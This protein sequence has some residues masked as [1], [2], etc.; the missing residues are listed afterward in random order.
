MLRDLP[1]KL[2]IKKLILLKIICVINFRRF[3]CP[4]KFFNNELFP[5][6]GNSN[7]EA[8]LQV[9]LN[10]NPGINS[11]VDLGAR[12][13]C[14]RVYC[15]IFLGI[16]TAA[17]EGRRHYSYEEKRASSNKKVYEPIGGCL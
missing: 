14:H 5:D 17:I 15:W 3:H 11:K 6:Y 13:C 4:R 12:Q 8:G 9:Y 16:Y 2:V 1:S 10:A 7:L